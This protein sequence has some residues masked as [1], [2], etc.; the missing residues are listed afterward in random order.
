MDFP[1]LPSSR[2]PRVYLC[3]GR[4]TP[5]GDADGYGRHSTKIL[6]Q[7]HSCCTGRQQRGRRDGSRG[8]LLLTNILVL[9][10]G[11]AILGRVANGTPPSGRADAQHCAGGLTLNTALM[12]QY[13]LYLSP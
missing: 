9:A 11:G 1:F 12:L 10:I 13:L 7:K 4:W 6:V 2:A 3:G 8:I 5:G